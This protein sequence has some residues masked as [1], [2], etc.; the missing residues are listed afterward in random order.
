VRGAEEHWQPM[1]TVAIGQDFQ[2][3]AILQV[4]TAA[5]AARYTVAY[6]I[7]S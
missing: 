5:T 7:T 2:D 3:A 4:V 1:L 6:I